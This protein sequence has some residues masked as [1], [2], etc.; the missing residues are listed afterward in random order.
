MRGSS[1][2]IA[3]YTAEEVHR[4]TDFTN[5]ARVEATT[6]EEIA[7]QAATDPDTAPILDDEALA[8]ARWVEPERKTAISLRVDPDVLRWF[9]SKGPRYQ[10]RMNRVLRAY[11]E[12]EE[13]ATA[14]SD[15]QRSR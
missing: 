5:E 4:A 9:R 14:A 13:R 15:S 11:M 10:S 12:S 2:R 7:A 8:R 3:R 1:K 6:D